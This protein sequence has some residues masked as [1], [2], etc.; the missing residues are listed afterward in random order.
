MKK[1]TIINKKQITLAVMVLALAAAVFL[2]MKFSAANGG[3]DVG[4]TESGIIGQT[5]FVNSE[6]NSGTVQDVAA[7]GY[8]TTAKANREQSREENIDLLKET[9]DNVKTDDAAKAKAVEQLAKITKCIEDETAIETLINAKGFPNV[10]VLIGDDSTNVVVQGTALLESEI[11][12]IK[13]CVISQI[14]IPIEKI[15]ILTVE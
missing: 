12:Q 5:E 14:G 11:Q 4:G 3:F 9:I 6:V 10:L 2:N 15:K 7:N 1:G 13:D 8:F